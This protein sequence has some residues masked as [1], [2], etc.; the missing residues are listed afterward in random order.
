MIT[1]TRRTE[2][3]EAAWSTNLLAPARLFGKST[4][5]EPTASPKAS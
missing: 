2:D 5:Q 3:I 1:K 4:G